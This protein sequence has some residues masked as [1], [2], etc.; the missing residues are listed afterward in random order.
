MLPTL[1]LALA[2]VAQGD[3]A[4]AKADAIAPFVGE[5]VAAVLHAD[6]AA[7]DF[8]R[9]VRALIGPLA[10]ERGMPEQLAAGAKVVADL[11]QAGAGD[12]YV[13]ID[14][15]DLP[16]IP[17]IVMPAARN[18][19]ALRD[20]VAALLSQ[21]G[22]PVSIEVV[23]GAV[24]AGSPQGLQRVRQPLPARPGLAEAFAATGDAPIRAVLLPS[25]AQR[26]AL[27]EALPE[28][29]AEIGGGPIAPFSEGLKWAVATL[30]VQPKPEFHAV[31]QAD[32]AESAKQIHDIAA[33]ALDAIKQEMSRS[34]DRAGAF[35]SILAAFEPRLEGDRIVIDIG[36]DKAVALIAGP[37][38]AARQA[39][40]RSQ[41]MNNLK[42]IGLALHNYH[43][44]HGAFPPADS[45]TKDGKPGLSWRVHIL[46]FIEQQPLYQEF[47]LDEPWDSEH[48]KALIEKMPRT[49]ADPQSAVGGEGKTVYLAPRGKQTI[50]PGAEGTRLQDVRDGTSNTIAVVQ[51]NDEHAVTWTR[52]DDW[53]VGDMPTLDALTGL[54]PN[55]FNALFG[56]GSVKFLKDT[57]DLMLFKALLTR[58]GGEVIAFDQID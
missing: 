45:K 37:I 19:N 39:A 23:R 13:L 9:D 26:R 16:G 34:P 15:L 42:Q 44:S 38:Q 24:V 11:K 8:E 27:E 43:D 6:L 17:L 33:R 1:T 35:A 5:E 40:R 49:Y 3:A 31:V 2:L 32:N 52:P 54:Y 10:D 30:R 14:P 56:D 50:F 28:L 36:A 47:H 58:N 4:K 20:A 41:G 25:D 21:P 22:L 18:P 51:A 46:P 55:G 12:A 53:E 29:P 57:I 7:I 48:N